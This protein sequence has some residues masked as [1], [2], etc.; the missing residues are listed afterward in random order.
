M[1]IHSTESRKVDSEEGGF[2]VERKRME[3]CREKKSVNL[4]EG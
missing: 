2:D 4:D 3:G 1:Y